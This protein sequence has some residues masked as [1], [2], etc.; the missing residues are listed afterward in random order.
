MKLLFTG[1]ICIAALMLNG[2][3][4]ASVDTSIAYKE[5]IKISPLQ[6]DRSVRWVACPMTN[7]LFESECTRK[8]VTDYLSRKVAYPEVAI[9]QKMEATCK[10]FFEIDSQGKVGESVIQR[11]DEEIYGPNLRAALSEIEFDPARVNGTKASKIMSV[12]IDF[13]FK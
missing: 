9:E 11:C 8:Y 2:Q 3:D 4:L 6:F 12:S 13:S 10:V 5:D 1:I 7:E